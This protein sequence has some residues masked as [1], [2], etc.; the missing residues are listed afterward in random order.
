VGTFHEIS[1]QIQCSFCLLAPR[2]GIEPLFST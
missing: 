2:R 1:Q